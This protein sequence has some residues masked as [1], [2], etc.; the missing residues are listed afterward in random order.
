MKDAHVIWAKGGAASFVAANDD[1]VTLSSSI[2]SPPGSRLEGTFL[3]ESAIKIK[4][5]NSKKES[6]GTFTL[7]GRLVDFTREMRERI[8]ALVQPAKEG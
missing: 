2:P 5:H 8:H 7:K 4:V 3:G 6:D 1:Q